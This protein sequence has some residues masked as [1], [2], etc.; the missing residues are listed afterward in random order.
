MTILVQVIYTRQQS[1]KKNPKKK[2]KN[3]DNQKAVLFKLTYSFLLAACQG[4]ASFHWNSN[5]TCSYAR[6]TVNFDCRDGFTSDEVVTVGFTS[7]GVVTV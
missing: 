2:K 3:E 7:N 5:T 6:G 4:W 1:V